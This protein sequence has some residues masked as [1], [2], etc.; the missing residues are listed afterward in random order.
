MSTKK[1]RN[2][3][4]LGIRTDRVYVNGESVDTSNS[5]R[6]AVMKGTQKVSKTTGISMAS[7][8]DTTQIAAS[9]LEN[10]NISVCCGMDQDY[11]L[12]NVQTDKETI[13]NPNISSGVSRDKSATDKKIKA[14][15]KF[16]NANDPI[17]EPDGNVPTQPSSN[18]E[19]IQKTVSNMKS[20]KVTI[21]LVNF[22]KNLTPQQ[23]L[24][25]LR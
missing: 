1:R 10:V 17:Y 13:D 25:Q 11:S 12:L 2:P 16:A 7:S 3:I 6:V 19:K 22:N 21:N 9:F 18:Q 14:T 8:S 4:S 5:I 23:Q 15:D 24:K 20:L